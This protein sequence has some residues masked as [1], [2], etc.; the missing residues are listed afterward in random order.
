MGNIVGRQFYLNHEQKALI[1][2]SLLGDARMESRSRCYSSRLRIHHSE[3]Q[4]EF[5]FWKYQ[6]MKDIVSCP[7]KRILCWI[8]PE[9]GKQYYSWYFHTRTLIELKDF[10]VNYYKGR[11]FLPL[12]IKDRL[13]PKSSAVWFM[14]DGCNTGDSVI[15][16]TQ[17]FNQAEHKRIIRALKDKFSIEAAINKDRKR[18]RIRLN[19]DNAKKLISIVSP[20]V[21]SCMR[22]KI[23]PVETSQQNERW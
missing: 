4:R 11:K 23:V 17:N 6:I 18:L 13:E 20:F 1:N 19:K 14:D 7:L 22:Y 15:L 8:N 10:Y 16:N 5:V 21:P 12:D 3:K 9:N 2:G